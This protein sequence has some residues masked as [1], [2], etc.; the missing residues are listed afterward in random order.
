VPRLV[1][2]DFRKDGCARPRTV[3]TGITRSDGTHYIMTVRA[4]RPFSAG[5][6][7]ISGWYSGTIS[8]R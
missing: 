8:L 6:K 4:L 2:F 5:S 1:D 7:A 3:K